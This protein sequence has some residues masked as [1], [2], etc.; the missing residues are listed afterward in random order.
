MNRLLLSAFCL[1][2]FFD[3][4]SQQS[5]KDEILAWQKN[6]DSEYADPD[7]SPLEKNEIKKFK[8]LKYFPI[9]SKYRVEAK[10][11]RIENESPF[12]MPTSTARK[13]IY[14][15]Y[16]KITFII[17]DTE[18]SLFVY[19]SQD[20][21]VKPEYKNHLFLP[22]TDMTNGDQ[23]YGGGRYIDI[24]IPDSDTMIVDFNKAYN[25]YCAYTDRYSC[26]IPP[27]ENNLSVAIE[28]GVRAWKN[29]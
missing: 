14:T 23:S 25:P 16:G 13:P 26:P 28:A 20:L 29:H 11:E 24:N 15:K 7:S 10:F 1:I 4:F 3:V 6:L 22:F 8:G 12:S 18:Y 27:R 9:D 19:Q 21:F 5:H 2:V 17:D